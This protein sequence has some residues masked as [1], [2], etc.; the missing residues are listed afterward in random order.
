MSLRR[1]GDV[2][3]YFMIKNTGDVDNVLRT[4]MVMVSLVLS[5]ERSEVA[6]DSRR[7]AHCNFFLSGDAHDW[8]KA[9]QTLT[10]A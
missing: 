2:A 3:S 7:P 4:L 6:P 1:N 5:W 10:T 9:T 8:A